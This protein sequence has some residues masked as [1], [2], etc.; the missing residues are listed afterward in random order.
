M[1]NILV[2]DDDADLRDD[3][4]WAV[5]GPGR[6]VILAASAKE[7]ADRIKQDTFQ[8]VVTDLQMEKDRSGFEVLQLAKEKDAYTQVIVVTSFSSPEISAEAMRM[9][10]FDFLDRRTL[11][12][13]ALEMLK[14]QA[15]LALAFR[16][17]KLKGERLEIS[18]GASTDSLED[19]LKNAVREAAWERFAILGPPRR[20]NHWPDVF[21]LMPFSEELQPIYHD[22]VKKVATDLDLRISRADNFFGTGPVMKDVWSAIHAARVVIADCT[23][24]NPNVFYEI[25]L[26][27]AIGRRTILVSQSMDDIPFDLRHLRV[28]VY[29]YTPPGMIEFEHALSQTIRASL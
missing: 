19:E 23:G 13:K 25:G 3:L 4:L 1:I 20:S 29:K 10:A 15:N 9:G 18:Q 22:H 11:K 7:A 21:V 16:G 27:H 26:A 8:L 24:R 5:K 12:T 6:E 2:V 14:N 28:I 17:A